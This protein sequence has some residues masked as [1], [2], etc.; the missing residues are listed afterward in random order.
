M[1]DMTLPICAS[2][3]KISNYAYSLAFYPLREKQDDVT[4]RLETE[5]STLAR[6]GETTQY[7]IIGICV[8]LVVASA[9]IIVPIFVWV[10]KDKS[11][12]LAIFSDISPEEAKRII[13]E[14]RQLD[15]KNLQFKRGWITRAGDNHEAF[16]KKLISQQRKGFGSSMAIPTHD[17]KLHSEKRLS[18]PAAE[19]EVPVEEDEEEMQARLDAER[20]KK[21]LEEAKKKRHRREKLSEIDYS[22]RNMFAIRMICVLLLFFVY[23]AV[24]LY[25]NYYVHNNNAQASEMLFDLCKR[26]LYVHTLNYLLIEAINLQSKAM[27]GINPN[28][29]GKL[30]MG[31]IVNAMMSIEYKTK[32]FQISA[33]R[34]IYGEFLDLMQ[35]ADGSGFYN[36]SDAY[37]DIEIT[38]VTTSSSIYTGP[39]TGGLTAG[40]AYYLEMHINTAQQLLNT[41]FSDPAASM[42]LFYTSLYMSNIGPILTFP[43]SFVLG[44]AVTVFYNCAARFFAAVR[45]IVYGASIGF[46]AV[47]AFIYIFVFARFIMTLNE[48]IWNTRGMINMIP[49]NV[50]EKNL[51]VREQVWMR[52]GL[53]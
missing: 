21:E 15:I 2:T 16:W 49:A 28:S 34:M 51:A 8:G 23:G 20:M 13:E 33:S 26:S 14:S 29:D 43:L 35:S 39:A 7:A 37:S 10:I 18:T 53:K 48:E 19:V 25:F 50:L 52:K 5:L 40:I 6:G 4:E 42:A 22:L 32:E 12:V 17:K 1:Y 45:K 44:G 24:E 31:D 38:N 30:Y 41:N 3:F 46:A 11:Y 9:C 36:I 27:V 47:F